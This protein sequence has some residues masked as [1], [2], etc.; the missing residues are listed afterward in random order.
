MVKA[1]GADGGQKVMPT[2]FALFSWINADQDGTV[3]AT[4]TNT[5]TDFRQRSGKDFV[6][7]TLVAP[8][9]CLPSIPLK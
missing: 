7:G 6:E 8:P 4:V 9:K 2:P 3:R 5:G 1:T